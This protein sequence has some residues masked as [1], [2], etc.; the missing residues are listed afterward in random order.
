MA[1]NKV[2]VSM[3]QRLDLGKWIMSFA[4]D[5]V[6]GGLKAIRAVIQRVIF[7]L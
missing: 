7:V 4:H 3:A 2:H 1:D 6:G 5:P